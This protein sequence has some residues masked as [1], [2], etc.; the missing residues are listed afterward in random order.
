MRVHVKRQ[1]N[2]SAAA[3]SRLG[4]RRATDADENT[5]FHPELRSVRPIIKADVT[6]TTSPLVV[7][8]QASSPKRGKK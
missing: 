2:K 1:K 4:G 6:R 8:C 7:C 3:T 5:D